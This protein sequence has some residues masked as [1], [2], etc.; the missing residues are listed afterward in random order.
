MAATQ[1]YYRIQTADRD[2]NNLLVAEHQ[3]S[4]AWNGNES[5]TRSGVSVCDSLESLAAYL[6]GAG[7]GIPYG[8]GE[9][10]IVEVAA[11]SLSADEP[12]DAE[13]GE[14]LV[15][16]T[17]ILSVTPMGDDFFEMIGAAYDALAA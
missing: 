7:S 2:V 15:Y 10:V 8:A 6:A 1:S 17:E 9:W 13:D 11:D 5:A 4:E 16:P 3:T 12:C 14:Y